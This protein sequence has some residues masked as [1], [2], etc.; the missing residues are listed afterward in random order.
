M[1]INLRELFPAREIG[2]QDLHGRRIAIDAY[3]TLF[4]FLS[5]IRDRF[6][7]EPLKDSQGRI[8]S[9]LSGLF[10][11]TAKLMENN[12]ELVYVFDGEPP[13]FKKEVREA[14]AKAREEAAREWKEALERGDMER[15]RVAAQASSRLTDE[16]VEESKRLLDAMGVPWIHAPSEGEAECA[17]LCMK[18]NVYSTA[19]QDADSL[20]FGSPRLVRNLTITGK[21]KVPRKEKYVTVNPEL[22]ELEAVLSS[23]G[24]N[25]EQL[26][27]L[28]I[29]VGTDYNPGGI[30]GIGPKRA[31]ELVKEK[32]TLDAV[33]ANV[34]WNF[35]P[36]PE[37][38]FNFFKNPPVKEVEIKKSEPEPDKVRELLVEEH[39]FSAERIS[40]VISSLEKLRKSG[41]QSSLGKFL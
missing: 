17:F 36:S 32:K 35:K 31:L 11:R 5:I 38:I 25:R 34:E 12:I 14:R 20:A 10:Y 22:I 24:I 8:T 23:L 33:F 28:G 1:G 7:G 15:A 9:H 6:T 19:S 41:R 2:I 3:N 21:R 29:L 13:E 18:G 16:M 40:S 4:Q 37:E 39:D 26:I 30:K 27:T